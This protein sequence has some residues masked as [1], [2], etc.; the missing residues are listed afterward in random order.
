MIRLAQPAEAAVVHAIMLDAYEEY[1]NGEAPSSALK[2]TED[3]ISTLLADR[4]EEAVLCFAGEL[5]AGTVRFRVEDG[6]YFLR[7]AVRRD[8]QGRGIAK[9]ILAWLEDYARSQWLTRIWCR[10]RRSVPRN[11][12]LYESLG[13][14]AVE[15]YVVVRKDGAQVPVATMV[16]SL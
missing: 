1:R 10:V 6:L 5:A 14:V 8:C 13:Y 7:L 3:Y 9:A 15:E 11:V 16:K 12:R 4:R 2:E